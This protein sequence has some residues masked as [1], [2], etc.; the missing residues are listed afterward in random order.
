MIIAGNG[1]EMNLW[2]C[3][4]RLGMVVIPAESEHSAYDAALCDAFSQKTRH[5]RVVSRRLQMYEVERRIDLELPM[6]G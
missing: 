1:W 5:L 4:D 3:A 6:K 2:R